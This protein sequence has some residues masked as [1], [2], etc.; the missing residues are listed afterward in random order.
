[1]D[2]INPCP[3][4]DSDETGVTQHSVEFNVNC[5]NCWAEGPLADTPEQ[6]V[7]AWNGAGRYRD[8]LKNIRNIMIDVG[9]INWL[10][11]HHRTAT[12]IMTNALGD[13]RY[14]SPAPE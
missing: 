8:I 13:G 1:M 6:A 12:N 7:A 5:T 4:C 11:W 2:T 3:F 10:V 14:E 9:H